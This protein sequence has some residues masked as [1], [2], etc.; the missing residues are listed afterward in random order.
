MR[1]IFIARHAK[2]EYNDQVEDSRRS[3]TAKGILDCSIT[4]NEIKS[5][6]MLE[7]VICSSAKRTYDTA[8][9]IIDNIDKSIKLQSLDNLYNASKEEILEVIRSIDDRYQTVLIIAHNPGISQ[10]V[11]DFTTTSK[12]SLDLLGK[13]SLGMS[14]A[15]VALFEFE[16]IWEDFGKTPLKIKDFFRPL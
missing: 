11:I 10:F 2:A 15:S 4:A 7:L 1:S 16:A 9:N 6:A 14:P 12:P 13:V 5:M 3:L 8:K